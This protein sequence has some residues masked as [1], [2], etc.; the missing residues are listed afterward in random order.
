[1]STKYFKRYRMEVDLR[2]H[3]PAPPPLPVGYSFVPWSQ[4]LL[5][6]H[7]DVKQRSF[8]WEIDSILFP[9]LGEFEGCQHLMREIASRDGFLPQA[10]WLVRYDSPDGDVEF[11]GTIQG[12]RTRQGVG[13]IQ[14][15]GTTAAHR[16]IGI[17]NA[18]VCRSL[19]GF[20][21][22]GVQRVFLEV[23]VENAGAVR[24]YRRLGF[25]HLRTVYKAA[26]IAYT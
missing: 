14:N 24:L 26:E 5:D 23:T 12:I 1:M 11:C 22:T 19:F 10:T 15:V 17:G 25:R 21:A 6:V 9:C 16:G 4:E 3:L 13:G 18:L 2:R 20:S 7:A 8:R